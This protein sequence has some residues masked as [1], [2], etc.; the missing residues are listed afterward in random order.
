M[1]TSCL[2]LPGLEKERHHTG[3]IF[4]YEGWRM[5]QAVDKQM[6]AGATWSSVT[7]PSKRFSSC[8]KIK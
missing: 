8:L 7:M 3:L 5:E 6:G 4:A 2:F 1:F